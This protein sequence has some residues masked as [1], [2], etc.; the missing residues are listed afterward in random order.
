MPIIDHMLEASLGDFL[1]ERVDPDIRHAPTLRLEGMTRR[2]DWY[3]EKHK[4]LVEFD[5]PLHFTKA[6]IA[7]RDVDLDNLWEDHGYFVIR[8]PYFVQL[9]G[10]VI[11]RL[12]GKYT[13]D[14]SPFTTYGHGFI[15]PKVTLP[16]DFCSYGV[17]RWGYEMCRLRE[18]IQNE[19]DATLEAWVSRGHDPYDVYVFNEAKNVYDVMYESPCVTQGDSQ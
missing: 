3:S 11:Y 6:K 17:V 18:D 2:P 7:R 14:Y 4:L 1:R 15:H 12:F 10:N 16:A 8:L 13:D 19:I 9:R 5:G